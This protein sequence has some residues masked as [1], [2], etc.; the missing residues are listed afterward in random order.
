MVIGR[1]MQSSSVPLRKL[2]AIL[3]LVSYTVL[4][5]LRKREQCWTMS[6]HARKLQA[7]TAWHCTLEQAASLLR[8]IGTWKIIPGDLRAVPCRAECDL[9]PYYLTL[10]IVKTT[11]LIHTQHG[12][13]RKGHS[14]IIFTRAMLIAF[15]Q[16][17]AIEG[18]YP[19]QFDIAFSH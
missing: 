17:K 6:L 10:H 4:S 11:S 3:L 1:Q 9:N 14:N 13:S 19:I 7:K 15:L 16:I 12:H 18:R 5:M 2:W 8:H